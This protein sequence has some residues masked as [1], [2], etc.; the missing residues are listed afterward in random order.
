MF[1]VLAEKSICPSTE[2]Q[3]LGA[4]LDL[5]AAYCHP[6]SR[7]PFRIP[8]ANWKETPICITYGLLRFLG[9]L[10]SLTLRRSGF[11]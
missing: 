11:L 6:L 2:S 9:D 4:V 10:L 1:I 8:F 3:V 5:A 7:V